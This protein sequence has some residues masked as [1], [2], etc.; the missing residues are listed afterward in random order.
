MLLHWVV[1]ESLKEIS[2][3]WDD[4]W[5]TVSMKAKYDGWVGFI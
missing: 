5:E 1:R 4:S 2:D 3:T